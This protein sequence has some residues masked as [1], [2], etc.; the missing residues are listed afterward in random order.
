MKEFVSGNEKHENDETCEHDDVKLLEEVNSKEHEEAACRFCW[1]QEEPE[2]NPKICVCQC[3]G[4]VGYI[5]FSC[6]KAWMKTKVQE[7]RHGNSVSQTWKQFECE[8]CKTRF[9]YAFKYRGKRWE[10]VDLHRPTSTETPYIIIES[11]SNDK[12][13]SRFVHTIIVENNKTE[14]KLGR[15]HESDLRV[16][17]ISVS[18]CHVLL[19]YKEGNFFL[20]DKKS[21][22]GT[23]VLIRKFLP[24]E[25]TSQMAV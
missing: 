25:P 9:P 19:K 23:L 12:N 6:L 7:V 18:R 3:S 5:H 8:L 20:E 22:F 16:N 11:L 15:G 24:I 17:D 2:D 21:K 4:S 14:F 13:N 10:M 1:S